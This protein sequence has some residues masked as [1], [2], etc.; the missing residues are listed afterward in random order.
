MRKKTRRPT[1]RPRPTNPPTTPPAMAPA[2]DDFLDTPGEPVSLSAGVGVL[3][4]MLGPESVDS[5]VLVVAAVGMEAVPEDSGTAR[6]ACAAATLNV[7]DTEMSKYAQAGIE[8]PAGICSGNTETNVF[9]QLKS[10]AD[11]TSN[12]RF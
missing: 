12:V 8:V 3:K 5:T 9:V 4:G 11:H 2:L 10:Q 1:M 7:S 6:S